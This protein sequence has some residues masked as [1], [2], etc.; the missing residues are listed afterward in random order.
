[1]TAMNSFFMIETEKVK[2]EI[3]LFQSCYEEMERKNPNNH[4]IN[5]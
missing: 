3:V 5:L 2:N 1:M 4:F